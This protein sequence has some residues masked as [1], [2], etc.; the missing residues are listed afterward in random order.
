MR[1]FTELAND[2]AN[3]NTAHY[4]FITPNLINDMHDS[5]A[6]LYN[7]VKQ[8]D[9]WLSQ[10]LPAI[11]NSSA[12]QNNGLVLITW[13]EG[14]NGDGPIGFIALSPLAK[15]GGY[16]NSIHYTHSSTLRTLQKIFGVTP[17]LGGAATAVDLSD[18]FV[19]NAIPNAD[20]EIASLN[21]SYTSGFATLSW[22]GQ[23]NITYR[24]QWKSNLLD[25]VW[26]TIIPDKVGNGSPLSW[27]DDGTQTGSVS[28]AQ[29]FYR[30]AIP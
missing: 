9:T 14:I 26:Q 8:G 7:P 1:P 18:L 28:P 29:R 15:G 4:N 16:H 12:Y 2:L 6:P 17:L 20:D 21:I 5:A 23:P 30:I 22:L 25:A 13:D 27:T 19:A 24:V 10:N 3:N 11:L